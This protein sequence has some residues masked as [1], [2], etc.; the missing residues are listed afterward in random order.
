M[1]IPAIAR[2]VVIVILVG[3]IGLALIA[4]IG[5]RIVPPAPDPWLIE[6]SMAEGAHRGWIPANPRLSESSLK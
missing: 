4:I 1:W 5:K 6:R 3:S 2:I